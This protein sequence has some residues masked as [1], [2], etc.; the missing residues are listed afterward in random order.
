CPRQAFLT[1]LT[2]LI[3]ASKFTQD[4]CHSNCAWAKLSSLLAREISHC[5]CV[6]GDA[7]DWRLWVSKWP[8]TRPRQQLL[9]LV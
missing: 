5:E 6:L 3:L 2:S 7:L 8:P 1:F 4:K 9:L